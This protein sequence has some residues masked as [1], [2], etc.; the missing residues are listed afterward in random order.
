VLKLGAESFDVVREDTFQRAWAQIGGERT[1]I[2]DFKYA[3]SDSKELRRNLA[4]AIGKTVLTVLNGRRVSLRVRSSEQD[5]YAVTIGPAPPLDTSLPPAFTAK[6][7][8]YLTYMHHYTKIHRVA[9]AETDLQRY[10][11]VSAP[12]VHDMVKTLER[13]GLIERTP[14]V[15]RSIRVLVRPEHLPRLG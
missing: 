15:G 10:F 11:G 12:A 9:P 5:A 2:L 7:G 3:E 4:D 8:Q 6:Q 13:N 1:R 14:G